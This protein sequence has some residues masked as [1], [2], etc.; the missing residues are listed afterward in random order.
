MRL[1]KLTHKEFVTAA[2]VDAVVWIDPAK[3]IWQ[4]GTKWPETK[5]RL[6]AA[7][8]ALPRPLLAP[9]TPLLKAREPFFVP[10]AGFGRLVPVEKTP[11]YRLAEDF[12]RRREAPETTIWFDMLKQELDAKGI[13]RH[14]DI[15]MQS[16]TEIVEF[17]TGYVGGIF[18]SLQS[19]GFREDKTGYASTAFITDRGALAKSGSGNHRFVIARIL[20]LRR[21]PLRIVGA[22]EDWLPGLSDQPQ[23]I[24]SLVA[25]FKPVE[26]AHA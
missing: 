13:A 8:R 10:R 25:A 9:L 24:P 16:D 2:G 1:S 6:K 17:L 20:G 26:Q 12:Y 11:R 4:A 3:V 14:K 23:D 7:R 15:A 19:E 18:D 5:R 22:H 21:Y